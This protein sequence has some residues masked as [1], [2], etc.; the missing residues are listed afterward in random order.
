[1]PK[2]VTGGTELAHQLCYEINKNGI[3][4]KMYYVDKTG[5]SELPMDVE[6]EDKFKKYCDVHVNDFNEADKKG[7][8]I[9][10]PEALTDWAFFFNNANVCIWWMSVDN[11]HYLGDDSYIKRLD[12]KTVYH[13]IQSNYAADYLRGK[14]I[15]ED[16][17]VWLSDYIG[18]AYMKFILPPVYR[19]DIILF[20][21]KKGFDNIKPLFDKCKFAQ[22]K[23][24]IN[25]TEEEM[26][27]NMQMAKIYIDFGNHPGKDRIPREAAMCGCLVL[28]N[29]KGSAAFRE[30]VPIDDE[31]KFE[32]PLDYEAITNKINEMLTDYEKHFERFDFYRAMI[33]SEKQFFEE[34]AR[35]F[36]NLFKE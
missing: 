36:V 8:V 27:L 35:G 6:T 25:M 18:D 10:V 16:K 9:I 14:N 1:M 30:D 24:L 31:Y 3:T 17:L 23:P 2:F 32:E 15:N 34:D 5:K 4:A 11:F 29:R 7:N 26:I 21:P 13:L 33:L 22:W 12:S 28:T 19:K 20:N